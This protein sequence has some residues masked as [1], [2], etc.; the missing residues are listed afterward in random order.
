M[1]NINNFLSGCE[2]IGVKKVD[3]F[4]TVDL[5]EGQNIPQVR[6]KNSTLFQKILLGNKGILSNFS[7]SP[8]MMTII[9]SVPILFF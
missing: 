8:C 3:L 7:G 4:Q 2:A 5:F 9:N 1:E 6:I